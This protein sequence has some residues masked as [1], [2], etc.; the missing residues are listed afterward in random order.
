ML[1]Y[2]IC[3]TAIRNGK[4]DFTKGKAMTNAEKIASARKAAE[5]KVREKECAAA[6]KKLR[7]SGKEAVSRAL[8]VKGNVGN[9]P[10]VKKKSAG[11]GEKAASVKKKNVYEM[12]MGEK[13]GSA[14][15]EVE[16]RLAA[17]VGSGLGAVS[18]VAG[19]ALTPGGAFGGVGRVVGYDSGHE[20]EGDDGRSRGGFFG[21]PRALEGVDGGRESVEDDGYGEEDPADWGMGYNSGIEG[22]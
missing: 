1:T 8:G 11:D 9:Y 7:N 2:V 15:A 18:A 17:S 21:G 14:G 13:S 4:W 5:K 6:A 20:S 12:V 22:E 16:E 10:A 19:S 3:V